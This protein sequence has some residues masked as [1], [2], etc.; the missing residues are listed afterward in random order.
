ME[1][2]LPAS[3][4]KLFTSLGAAFNLRHVGMPTWRNWQTR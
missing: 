4:T 2:S 3:L 1:Q